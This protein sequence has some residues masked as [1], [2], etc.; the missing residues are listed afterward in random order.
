MDQRLEA[1]GDATNAR[2]EGPTEGEI[3]VNI[4][5]GQLSPPIGAHVVLNRTDGSRVPVILQ[6]VDT[7]ITGDSTLIFTPD[8]V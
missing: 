8:D 3:R 6:R 4:G 2:P 7:D 1:A 5:K